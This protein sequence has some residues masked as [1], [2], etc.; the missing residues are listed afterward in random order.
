M[1][2]SQLLSRFA[3]K[4]DQRAFAELVRR[5]IDLVYGAALRHVNGDQHRAED[6]AQQVFIDLAGKAQVLAGHPCLAGWL[7]ASVRFTAVN[8]IRSEQRRSIREREVELMKISED[9]AEPRWEQIRPVIDEA[10]EELGEEDRQSVLLRFFGRQTFGVIGQQ[11][12]LSENA[13]QKRVDRALDH[14]NVA[15]TRRGL[16]STAAVLSAGLA[17][18][19]VTAPVG[20][21]AIISAGATATAAGGVVFFMN[22]TGF[23]IG[24]VA[25]VL[26]LGGVVGVVSRHKGAMDG[27]E[28]DRSSQKEFALTKEADLPTKQGGSDAKIEIAKPAGIAA[29]VSMREIS[30]ET[31]ILI[32]KFPSKLTDAETHILDAHYQ[33]LVSARKILELSLAQTEEVKPG[34]VLITIPEYHKRGLELLLQYAGRLATEIGGSRGKQVARESEVGVRRANNDFGIKEQQILIEFDGSIYR[35]VHGSGFA[36]KINDALNIGTKTSSSQ[37]RTQDVDGSPYSYLRPFFPAKNP[38]SKK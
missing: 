22:T 11:L 13:A 12:G 14:L 38:E 15:L 34:T 37:V 2:D 24:A 21:V 10:M 19:G 16:G 9:P 26:I 7:Y 17:H 23:K 27:R 6:V 8:S 5:N 28:S 29:A 31:K 1:T 20:L 35:V 18:A 36:M 4:G 32:E 3:H 33:D 25:A 30:P